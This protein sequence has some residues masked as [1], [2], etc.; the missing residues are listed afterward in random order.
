MIL[1]EKNH[2]TNLKMPKIESPSLCH[3]QSCVPYGMETTNRPFPSFSHSL[4][5]SESKRKIFVKVI[6]SNLYMN[7]NWH[8]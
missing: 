3:M 2:V 8:S 5:Q 1:M 6:S 4:F 7:E